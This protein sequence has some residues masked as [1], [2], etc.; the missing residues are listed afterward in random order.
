[1]GGRFGHRLCPRCYRNPGG[2]QL[3]G[4][5]LPV[6]QLPVD[7]LCIGRHFSEQRPCER[8]PCERLRATRLGSDEQCWGKGRDGQFAAFL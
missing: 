5:Q 4:D 1:M 3:C 7:Q 2:D 8:R 6:D